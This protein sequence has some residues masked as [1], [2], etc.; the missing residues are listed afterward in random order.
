MNAREKKKAFKKRIAKLESD[1]KLMKDI[2][3]NHPGMAELYSLYNQPCNVT[4]STM[5]FREYRFRRV[6]PRYMKDIEDYTEHIKRALAIDLAEAIRDD[7]CFEPVE[8]RGERAIEA[9]VFIGKGL[10]D[11]ILS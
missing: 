1:N 10:N 2:I 9:S 11:E 4:H 8:I 7:I 5:N 3:K 6:I